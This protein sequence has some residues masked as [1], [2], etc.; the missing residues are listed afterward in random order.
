MTS[1]TT[2][3]VC[4]QFHRRP[5]TK[6]GQLR[7]FI[8]N[9][10]QFTMQ[11]QHCILVVFYLNE[12]HFAAASSIVSSSNYRRDSKSLV[13]YGAMTEFAPLAITDW[14]VL[15]LAV[16]DVAVAAHCALGMRTVAA[17][18]GVAHGKEMTWTNA[19]HSPM[20]LKWRLLCPDRAL[21][22]KVAAFF[23]VF[24]H[25]KNIKRLCYRN[26][27]RHAVTAN[28]RVAK[29]QQYIISQIAGIDKATVVSTSV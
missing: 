4:C 13:Q 2:E 21:K 29:V 26:A 5:Q 8:N 19:K 12:T 23:A 7:H 11:K 20:F 24:N 3:V 18:Y 27:A 1:R 9:V 17:D 28:K 16:A 14:A 15:P 10:I 25:P 22:L 6:R